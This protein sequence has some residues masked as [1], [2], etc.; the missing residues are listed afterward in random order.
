MKEKLKKY[1]KQTCINRFIELKINI[2]SD[3]PKSKLSP[4]KVAVLISLGVLFLIGS[5]AAFYTYMKFKKS[6]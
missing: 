1:L 5:A 4:V 6:G 3:I 2:Y